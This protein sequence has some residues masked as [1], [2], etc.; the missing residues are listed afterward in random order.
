M[1][2]RRVFALPESITCEAWALLLS[3][4]G[5]TFAQVHHEAPG[6]LEAFHVEC[7]LALLLQRC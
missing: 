1:G 3:A 7:V 5:G 4:S 6:A 2:R